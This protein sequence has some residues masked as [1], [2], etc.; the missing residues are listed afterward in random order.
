MSFI[1][2]ADIGG[3]KTL[4]Q[5][6]LDAGD[7]LYEESFPSQEFDN[8]ES[9]LTAFCGRDAVKGISIASACFAVAGPVSGL[10]A[11]VTNLPWQLDAKQLRQQFKID[12]VKLCNDFEAVG[13]GI[14]CLSDNDIE[15][16]QV[17][18]PDNDA[19]RAV[20]C[21][22]AIFRSDTQPKC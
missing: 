21:I 6:S 1:L 10:T 8:F 19:A 22:C 13:Y 14:A 18:M 5:L 11:S 4:L 17:G 15:T 7:V 2:A 9:V 20:I 12:K 3:T 16:L